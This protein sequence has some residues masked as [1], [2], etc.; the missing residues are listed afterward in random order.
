MDERITLN[1]G[2]IRW[3]RI[4]NIA[5][6]RSLQVVT[7]V[8]DA[9]S[10]PQFDQSQLD[11]GKIV[12][13]IEDTLVGEA[14]RWIWAICRHYGCSFQFNESLIASRDEAQSLD[15]ILAKIFYSKNQQRLIIGQNIRENGSFE[16]HDIAWFGQLRLKKWSVP[17]TVVLRLVKSLRSSVAKFL[18][19]FDSRV[20]HY[21]DSAARVELNK[22]LF[23]DSRQDQLTWLWNRMALNDSIAE[24]SSSEEWEYAMLI[25]D[26]DHF[27]SINDTFSH[28]MWDKALR[29]IALVFQDLEKKFHQHKVRFFRYGWEEFLGMYPVNDVTRNLP[30]LL[31]EEIRNIRIWLSSEDRETAKEKKREY[32]RREKMKIK[33]YTLLWRR[34]V[35]QWGWVVYENKFN[36]LHPPLAKPK[37][38]SWEELSFTASIGVASVHLGSEQDNNSVLLRRGLSAADELVFTAKDRWRNQIVSVINNTEQG[39]VRVLKDTLWGWERLRDIHG[40]LLEPSDIAQADSWFWFRREL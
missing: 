11:S 24:V 8:N 32:D 10:F 14:F 35:R 29:A 25:L 17:D 30:E 3:L 6:K 34:W 27:K 4:D 37:E 23:K 20:L 28:D 16:H 19:D 36:K 31:L 33:Y 15:Q 26:T 40:T 1:E 9:L 22:Q 5:L 2:Q 18:K 7:K 13:F 12:E 38:V 21:T 39:K